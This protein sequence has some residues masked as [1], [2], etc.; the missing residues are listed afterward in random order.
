MFKGLCRAGVES[1]KLTHYCAFVF[2]MF[3]GE[4]NHKTACLNCKERSDSKSFFWTLPLA[5][6]DLCGQTYSVVLVLSFNENNSSVQ[7]LSKIHKKRAC[8]MNTVFTG[9]RTEGVLQG[10]NSPWGQQDVLQP[11]QSK[12]RCRLCEFPCESSFPFYSWHQNANTISQTSAV[13]NNVAKT[14]FPI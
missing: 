2:E 10:R 3:K 11:L 9:E 14:H 6:K 7:C 4:L 12:A 1:L 13:D 5:A 8:R